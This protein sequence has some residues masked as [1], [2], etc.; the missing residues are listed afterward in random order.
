MNRLR[1]RTAKEHEELKEKYKEAVQ[2]TLEYDKEIAKLKKQFV[3][4]AAK[5]DPSD[6][7]DVL[8]SGSDEPKQFEILTDAFRSAAKKL[9]KAAM[10]AL[11][12]EERGENYCLPDYFANETVCDAA[13]K[14]AE[15]QFVKIDGSVVTVMSSHPAVEEAEARLDELRKF[16][17]KA[18][19]E[20]SKKYAKDNGHLFS[21]RN[22]DFWQENLGL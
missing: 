12:S 17:V 8:L 19:D 22:R 7:R 21:I 3:E 20:L 11:F 1:R 18:S 16:M 14:A 4:L 13:Q 6:V 15:R 5:R 10:E 9:P 2:A